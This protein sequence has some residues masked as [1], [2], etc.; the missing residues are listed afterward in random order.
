[1]TRLESSTSKQH[2]RA[3]C[4]LLFVDDTT[5]LGT[6]VESDWPLLNIPPSLN[7]W[8]FFSFVSSC[9]SWHFFVCLFHLLVSPKRRFHIFM[10]RDNE[11]NK[12][13][14]LP[15]LP[16]FVQVLFIHHKNRIVNH[17]HTPFFFDRKKKQNRRG[18]RFQNR[19]KRWNVYVSAGSKRKFSCKEIGMKE[20][21]SCV[22]AFRLHYCA[23]YLVFWILHFCFSFWSWRKSNGREREERANFVVKRHFWQFYFIFGFLGA[24][25]L[26]RFCAWD[27]AQ[28]RG[29][30]C[31]IANLTFNKK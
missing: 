27:C 3:K 16:M 5:T 24:V 14:N 6:V 30:A 17:T 19:G 21:S 29:P 20:T 15:L 23:S 1:M 10:W 11:K 8:I 13:A 26:S 22:G 28:W 31:R 7:I 12:L 4:F 9:S 25:P 18:W 2:K